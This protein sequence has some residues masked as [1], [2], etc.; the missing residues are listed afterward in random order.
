MRKTRV[1]GL[2]LLAERN[3]RA[4]QSS[5]RNEH[6]LSLAE[7][8]PCGRNEMVKR[9]VTQSVFNAGHRLACRRVLWEAHQPQPRRS[10]NQCPL[11]LDLRLCVPERLNRSVVHKDDT[12]FLHDRLRLG[13]HDKLVISVTH[14]PAL[15]LDRL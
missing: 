11:A 2:K 10:Q 5:I 15:G 1:S 14:P 4:P 7:R 6:D 8:E 13:R 9:G 12:F 3:S